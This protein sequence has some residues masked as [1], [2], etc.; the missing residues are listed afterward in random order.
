MGIFGY[1]DDEGRCPVFDGRGGT[2]EILANYSECPD[3]P[4]GGA[5]ETRTMTPAEAVE[6]RIR[7]YREQHRAA[8]YREAYEAV[9]ADPVLRA[10]Y[11]G[12]PAPLAASA[13]AG[14]DGDPADDRTRAGAFLDRFATKHLDR[15]RGD[16]AA[17]FRAAMQANPG[18]A[19]AYLGI[20]VSLDDVRR[21]LGPSAAY[22][23][24]HGT[25]TYQ[26]SAGYQALPADKAPSGEEARKKLWRR[27][28]ELGHLSPF[29]AALMAIL[30]SP[31][32]LEILQKDQDT[33]R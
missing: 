6:Q 5:M 33:G 4:P 15:F 25:T 9:L 30:E 27:A 1:V 22:A 8:T 7:A 17:A 14:A 2:R 10:A 23:V 24:T 28:N 3:G 18:E 12:A 29:D 20:G 31:E 13:P 11:T 26:I 32:L 19:R 16:Y 21:R